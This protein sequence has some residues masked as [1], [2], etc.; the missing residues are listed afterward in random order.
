MILSRVLA[1]LREEPNKGD[2]TKG[3]IKYGKDAITLGSD[4]RSATP[5]D[6]LRT[7]RFLLAKSP[8]TG[9]NVLKMGCRDYAI[10]LLL[11]RLVLRSGEVVCLELDGIDWNAGELSVRGKSGQRSELPLPAEVGQA[12]AR[13]LSAAWTA[14]KYQSA[15]I[16]TR[17][18]SHPWLSRF[19]WRRIDRSALPSADT[20]SQG[21]FKCAEKPAAMLRSTSFLRATIIGRG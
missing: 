5:A 14:A 16:S 7:V 15:R 21:F 13:R 10:L 19:R 17:Q 2:F 6:K 12:I 3:K 18:S 9:L 8:T 4:E 1:W 20:P 11:A